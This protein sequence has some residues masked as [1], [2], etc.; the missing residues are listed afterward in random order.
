MLSLHC[1]TRE[2]NISNHFSLAKY[3]LNIYMSQFCVFPPMK[4]RLHGAMKSEYIA[5]IIAELREE[6]EPRKLH[7]GPHPVV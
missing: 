4:G 1:Y 5:A 7:I 6:C 2:A 3:S